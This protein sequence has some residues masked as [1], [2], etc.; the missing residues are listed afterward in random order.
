MKQQYR[1]LA[2]AGLAL[3]AACV[4]R[5]VLTDADLVPISLSQPAKPELIASCLNAALEEYHWKTLEEQP[6]HKVVQLARK[7][8]NLSVKLD[9]AY[10]PTVVTI[11]F[12]EMVSLDGEPI[13]QIQINQYHRWTRALR[14]SMVDDLNRRLG[15]T[16]QAAY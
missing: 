7:P 15:S 10:T 4:S 8:F 12:L 5:P 11:K 2:C 3:L 6:G 16:A 14:Q 1:A 9:I 13:D